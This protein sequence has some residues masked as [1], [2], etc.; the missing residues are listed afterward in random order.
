MTKNILH[1][2]LGVLLAGPL[3]AQQK[4]TGNEDTLKTTIRTVFDYKPTIADARKL[5][6]APFTIDT[7]LPKPE[8]NYMYGSNR[9]ET[10]FKPDSIQAAKMK[11]EPLDP[12]YRAYT[13]IGAGNGINYLGD[14]YVNTVRSRNGSMGIEAHGIGTQGALKDLPPAP[15]NRWNGEVNGK[16]FFKKHALEGAVFYDRER[17]QNYG[18]SYDDP[19]S[20]QYYLDYQGN[21]GVFKQA[22]QRVGAEGNLKSFY[23][24]STKLNHIVALRYE[25]WMDL[26]GANNE[27]NIAANGEVSRFFGSHQVKVQ[28]LVDM[29][30]VNYVDS[31]NYA[32]FGAVEQS[33]S[34]HIIGLK[35]VMTSQWKKFRVEY[36]FNVQAQIASA[37]TTPRIYP[38]LYAKYNLL[39]DV[40]IPYAGVTGGLQR[41]NLSNLTESNP[42]LLTRN[43][44]LRNTDEVLNIYGGFRGA[45]SREIT[46]NL[47]ASRY[48]QRNAP[49]FINY[50]ASQFNLGTSRFG[51]NYFLVNYD[52]INVFEI[53]GE[54]MYRVGDKIQVVGTGIY[55]SYQ[56]EVEF[57]AWQ[58]PAIEAGLTGFYQIQNKI[59]IKAQAHILGPQWTKS[60]E[61]TSEKFFGNDG[62]DVYGNKLA[63]VIDL[64]AGLEYRYTERL[65]GFINVNNFIA[66]RYQRW[67]QY[68]VQRINVIGGITYSFW[69]E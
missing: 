20:A 67:N 4:R 53:S 25:N 56:T 8:P 3:V 50:N 38:H 46:Y 68:P 21:E 65:S 14:L 23:T 64:N 40:L 51:E 31:F 48:L 18:Y 42:F 19:A 60:Y 30:L 52:T 44:M 12:L 32:P 15:Y 63:P 9:M 17:L 13:R 41:N 62:K 34:N 39:K 7:V 6:E 43:T 54:L 33:P 69:K 29:N 27:N 11:G 37:G 10:E 35:P 28:A 57:E 47:Q 55:R 22:Y 24:D 58:R 5:S 66:Q 26:H 2:A 59:I 49:M 16:R 1:I 45:I 61:S 36:G